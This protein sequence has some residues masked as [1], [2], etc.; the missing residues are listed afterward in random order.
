[1]RGLGCFLTSATRSLSQREA[2][3]IRASG[4]R[5]AAIWCES[6]DGRRA[7]AAEVTALAAAL[8][9]A[10]VEPIVWTFPAPEHAAEAAAHVVACAL[11]MGARLIV[12][13]VEDPDG[14]R[15]PMDWSAS[16]VGVLLGGIAASGVEIAVTSYPGRRGFGLPWEA[17]RAPI[18]MPQIYGTAD[19]PRRA[20]ERRE[21]WR[22][23]H[24]SVTPVTS[25]RTPGKPEDRLDGARLRARLDAVCLDASGACVV[26]GACVWSWSLLTA[27]HRRACRE[28]A[29]AR[30]W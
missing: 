19:D 10:G 20:R 4:F 5:W 27:E 16:S 17:M 12:V 24:G 21:E 13:D 6:F 9:A 26:D 30:G 2:R 7:T 28:W 11:A 22:A 15:G 25:V 1:M 3:L 29:A 14:A 8:C 23:A 18:G